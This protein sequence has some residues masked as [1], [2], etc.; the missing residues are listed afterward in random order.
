MVS[1]PNVEKV[2]NPP[3]AP[4][5]PLPHFILRISYCGMNRLWN[6]GSGMQRHS[7]QLCGTVALGCGLLSAVSHNVGARG[8]APM[9]SEQN[10]GMRRQLCFSTGRF[11]DRTMGSEERFVVEHLHGP[12]TNGPVFSGDSCEPT[13]AVALQGPSRRSTTSSDSQALQS[14][15]EPFPISRFSE[16]RG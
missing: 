2:A 6:V 16:A 8:A 1:Y 11:T 15:H 4:S 14:W 9:R 10:S 7:A 12:V 5:K 13:G 3:S